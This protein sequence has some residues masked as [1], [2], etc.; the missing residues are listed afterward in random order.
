MGLAG[1]R[2]TRP[3]SYGNYGNPNWKRAPLDPVEPV[4]VQEVDE[5]FVVG[6]EGM[7]E[8]GSDA[9]RD[10]RARGS[11]YDPFERDDEVERRGR[12]TERG[13]YRYESRGFDHGHGSAG[14][15]D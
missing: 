9:H 5:R 3:I 2:D 7:E 11:T 15:A 10:E 4:P 8:V 13:V 6:E 14:K 1:A 12:T